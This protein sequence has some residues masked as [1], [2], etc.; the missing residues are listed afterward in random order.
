M[1]RAF[2]QKLTV[3]YSLLLL[4]ATATAAEPVTHR[5]MVC[6]Y[7]EAGHRLVEIGPDGKLAWEHKISGRR[8]LLSHGG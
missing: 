6:E 4:T 5:I 8:R 1:I 7:S 2:L 3:S